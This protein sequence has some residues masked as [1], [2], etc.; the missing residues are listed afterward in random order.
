MY[1]LGLLLLLRHSVLVMLT[2]MMPQQVVLMP[3]AAQL[4]FCTYIPADTAKFPP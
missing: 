1:F 3:D 2:Y 4:F